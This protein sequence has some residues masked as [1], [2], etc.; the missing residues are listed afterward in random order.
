[1]SSGLVQFSMQS[2]VLAFG[3]QKWVTGPLTDFPPLCK[4]LESVSPKAMLQVSRKLHVGGE[5]NSSLLRNGIVTS[6]LKDVLIQCFEVCWLEHGENKEDPHFGRG[7]KCL[8]AFCNTLSCGTH[9][10]L[11]GR[12][13]LY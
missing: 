3:R 2:L 12:L 4:H 5:G 6:V 8:N 9:D 10:C 7:K 13:K 11:L 1:M